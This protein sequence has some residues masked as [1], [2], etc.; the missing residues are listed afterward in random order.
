M[1]PNDLMLPPSDRAISRSHC[2]INYKEFF[3]KE[4][5]TNWMAFLMAFHPRLGEKSKLKYLPIEIV[6]HI[7]S[8]LRF[9]RLPLLI[10]LGSMCGTYVKVSNI[11]PIELINGLSLIVGS[12]III[13]ID[14]VVNEFKDFDELFKNDGNNTINGFN[15]N[16]PFV[17]IKV[18][19]AFSDQDATM[20]V[21]T[22]KF[23]A[24]KESS[25]FT[26]GRSQSC[27]ININENTIS[28]IQCRIIFHHKK[29][30][31]LDGSEGKPTVN[32]TWLS[33]CKRTSGVREESDPFALKN[34]SQ[35]KVSDTILE[36]CWT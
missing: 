6:R 16:L 24:S 9:V 5:P 10:D 3:N 19:K 32:G 31:L 8:F 34:G 22:Y 29:W 4:I 12:D 7:I 27:D 28:R 25:R 35:I 2:M 33:I 18:S 13:E 30:V 11:E 17:I 26:I 36:V 23:E 15:Y 20:S 21:Q 14:R 1:R